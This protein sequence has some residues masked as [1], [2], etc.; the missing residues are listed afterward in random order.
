M[1]KGMGDEHDITESHEAFEQGKQAALDG[2]QASVNP[3]T[4]GSREHKHWLKGYEF[5]EKFD[6]DG[7][8][9]SDT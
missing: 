7:E 6:E 8:V 4:P 3:Y 1:E 2:Q 9:P 5:V